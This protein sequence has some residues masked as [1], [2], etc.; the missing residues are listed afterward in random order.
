MQEFAKHCR[1]D[2]ELE[3]RALYFAFDMIAQ[4]TE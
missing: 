1:Y 3:E 2:E 4:I